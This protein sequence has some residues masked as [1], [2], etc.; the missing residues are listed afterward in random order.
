MRGSA[1]PRFG[2]QNPQ[3][4][5]LDYEAKYRKMEDRKIGEGKIVLGKSCN[6]PFPLSSFPPIFLSL[7][8]LSYS[9]QAIDNPCR[10]KESPIDLADCRGFAGLWQGSP[11]GRENTTGRGSTGCAD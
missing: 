9:S 2:E 11:P 6:L 3:V 4:S 5:T 7:M 10:I 1:R 8:F